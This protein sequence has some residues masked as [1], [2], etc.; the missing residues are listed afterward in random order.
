M[1]VVKGKYWITRNGVKQPAAPERTF[2]T[3]MGM[4]RWALDQKMIR[5]GA[6]GNSA[7]GPRE[8]ERVSIPYSGSGDWQGD[9]Y[10]TPDQVAAMGRALSRYREILRHYREIEPEWRPDT[11]VSSTGEIYYADNSVEL[12]EINKY[13]ERRHRMVTAPSG[14]ICF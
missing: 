7:P 1:Y 9:H 10:F 13:G 6:W 2:I 8:M 5:R 11:S 3:A 12:H 4:L 14:D